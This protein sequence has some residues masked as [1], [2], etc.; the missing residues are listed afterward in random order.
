MK[1]EAKARLLATESGKYLSFSFHRIPSGLKVGSK[2]VL[3]GGYGPGRTPKKAYGEV[4]EIRPDGKAKIGITDHG[5]LRGYSGE[6]MV[7]KA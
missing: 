3:S 5:T 7:D 2:V 4:V 6:V 1:I